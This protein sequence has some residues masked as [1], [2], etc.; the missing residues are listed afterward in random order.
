MTVIVFLVIVIYIFYILVSYFNSKHI[1]GYEV[2][3]GSLAV[4]N[5]FRGVILR[6]EELYTSKD[7]GYVNYYARE[8]EKV[9]SGSMVYTVDES[10]KLND[11]ISSGYETGSTLTNQDLEELKTDI[12]NYR[13]TY[14]DFSF[15]SVYDFKYSVQGTVTKLANKNVLSSL[16]QVTDKSV[17][18]L[19]KYD[20]AP[21]S[22]IVVYSCDGLEN[23]TSADISMDTFNEEEH[24]KQQLQSNALIASGDPVYKLI[25]EE[26]WSVVIPV[27]EGYILPADASD[28]EKKNH[29]Y[30]GDY[31]KVRFDKSGEESW[32]KVS[33]FKNGEDNFCRLDFTN[34]MISF[35]TDRYIDIELQ[36]NIKKGLKIPKSAIVYKEFYIIPESCIVDDSDSEQAG[37]LRKVYMDD[38]KESSERVYAKVYNRDKGN[39]YVDIS[40]F[41][42][43]DELINTDKGS[44]VLVA[45]T[46]TMTGVYNINK[47]YADFTRITIE[48]ENEEYAIVSSDTNYGLIVYDHIVLD[49]DAVKD[50]DFI[51]E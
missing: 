35:A 51:Y 10:G 32:G 40:A 36:L 24:A 11:I 28:S 2:M 48:D 46:E 37:F 44:R 41:N 5:T 50:D 18:D 39:V 12:M 6:T 21:K 1:S 27:E 23:L 17:L 45:Q 42:K 7:N 22:G 13:N 31:V 20:Y 26:N 25:T 38:G 29:L 14:S 4:N 19:V 30:D 8:G 15:D 34:S 47:G 16:S 9:K 43:N 49:G 3:E 33:S